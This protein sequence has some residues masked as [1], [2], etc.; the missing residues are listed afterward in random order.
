[1][2]KAEIEKARV[3]EKLEETSLD[4]LESKLNKLQKDMSL[5]LN[6]LRREIEKRK[7]SSDHHKSNNTR[8]IGDQ[9]VNSSFEE[10]RNAEEYDSNM[11]EN[12]DE[13]IMINV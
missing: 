8:T 9:C 7:M 13:I 12:K 3:G 6:N 4:E 2:T 1:V 10:T 5:Q 11:I